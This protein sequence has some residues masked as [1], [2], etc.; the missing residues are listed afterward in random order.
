MERLIIEYLSSPDMR[1][2]SGAAWA[3]GEYGSSAAAPPLWNAL[4]DF[5]SQWKGKEAQLANPSSMGASGIEYALVIA[6]LGPNRAWKIREEDL[7]HLQELCS[8]TFCRDEILRWC[9]RARSDDG[10]AVDYPRNCLQ[11]LSRR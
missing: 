9:A 7:D 1:I 11:W 6:L 3:L 5:H 8:T 4:A 2:K 10:P